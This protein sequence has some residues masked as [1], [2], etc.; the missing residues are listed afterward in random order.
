MYPRKRKSGSNSISRYFKKRKVYKKKVSKKSHYGKRKLRNN[1][2][3][4]SHRT[5]NR[6]WGAT[7]SYGRKSMPRWSKS[8]IKEQNVYTNAISDQFQILN[9]IGQQQSDTAD[10]PILYNETDLLAY[11]NPSARAFQH[12]GVLKLLAT[13]QSDSNVFID[14][15]EWV[16]RRDS[17]RAG[18]ATLYA[19]SAGPNYFGNTPFQVETCV[20][21]CKILKVTRYILAQGESF[22][23]VMHVYP[24]KMTDATMTGDT[25]YKMFRGLTHGILP[26]QYGAPYNDITTKTQ[27]SLGKNAVDYVYSKHYYSYGITNL[28]SVH[29]NT[30]LVTAFTIA[31][32]IMNED[33]GV[34]VAYV[35]A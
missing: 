1:L 20:Q 30:N 34:A 10:K 15:Y 14:L 32:D 5:G 31:E 33:S 13:N 28:G 19:A 35:Q 7:H 8:L 23:H 26:I 6:S 12:H 9:L 29:D 18:L 11:C 24:N 3:G 21:T 22:E 25:S 17:P 27:I 4:K 16:A 2:R